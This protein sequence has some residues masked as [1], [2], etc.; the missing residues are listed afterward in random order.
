MRGF[1]KGKIGPVDGND[2]IGGNYAAAVNFDVNLPKPIG[3]HNKLLQA[4]RYSTIGA[5]NIQLLAMGGGAATPPVTGGGESGVEDE[6]LTFF[7]SSDPNQ[8][9]LNANIDSKPGN[10]AR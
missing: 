9:R 4:M 3:I 2:H 7:N 8:F 6:T 5:G 10:N 1:S